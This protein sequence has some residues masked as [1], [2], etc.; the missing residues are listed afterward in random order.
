MLAVLMSSISSTPNV[1]ALMSFANAT[2]GKNPTIESKLPLGQ[3]MVDIHVSL[4]TTFRLVPN[5]A[6]AP[7][8]VPH[9][10]ALLRWAY[11]Q[12]GLLVLVRS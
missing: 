11:L 7:E 12:A 4:T 10:G 1:D 5:T 3:V 9:G 2:V 6:A 8:Y